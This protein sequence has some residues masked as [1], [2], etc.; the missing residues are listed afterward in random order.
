MKKYTLQQFKKDAGLLNP[1]LIAAV[2]RQAGGWDEFKERAQDIANHGAAGGFSGF[3]YYD[4]TVAFAKK[5][6]TEIFEL[7]SQQAQEFGEDPLTM[8]ANFNYLKSS[9]YTPGQIT[10]AIYERA[11][12]DEHGDKTQILNALAWYALE[13]VARALADMQTQND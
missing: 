13:E 6:K 5:H 2:V 4:D 1:V 8:I 3:I 12:T 9:K 11:R 10:R 7:A